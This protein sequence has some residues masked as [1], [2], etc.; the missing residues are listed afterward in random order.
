MRNSRLKLNFFF[1]LRSH[2]K[3]YNARI[4]RLEKSRF[5]APAKINRKLNR[6]V[7]FMGWQKQGLE[8]EQVHA[9]NSEHPHII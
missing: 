5:V 9:H 3:C 2:K 4:E 1:N 8:S 7:N 6:R